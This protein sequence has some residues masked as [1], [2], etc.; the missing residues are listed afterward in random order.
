[1]SR[2]DLAHAWLITGPQYVGRRICALDM[3][4]AANCEEIRVADAVIPC[5]ECQQ[6]T[7]I[8]SAKH[9]DIRFSSLDTLPKRD[10]TA[11]RSAIPIEEIHEIRRLAFLQPLEGHRRVFIIGDADLLSRDAANALLKTLEE[12]PETVI[13]I[14][15]ALA[16]SLLP[17]TI[18][19]RCMKLELLPVSYQT[20]TNALV[21]D[22]GVSSEEAKDITYMAQGRIG[23]A[24]QGQSDSSLYEKAIQAAV[25]AHKMLTSDLEER[26]A[27][28]RNLSQNTRVSLTELLEELDWWL[29]WW[30]D[31]AYVKLDRSDVIINQR[32][33]TTLQN[34]AK[35]LNFAEISGALESIARAQKALRSNV[36]PALALEIMAFE[37]P[38][39]GLPNT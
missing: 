36:N 26:L 16:P 1:M 9:S 2:G 6:C 38:T 22:F 5:G 8:A 11:R 31:L 18:V 23:W 34:V 29:S 39:V 3:A 15:L 35:H 25:R 37:L 27:T 12:P 33:A 28:A 7:R 24:M 21:S 19:S 30:R 13:I 20:I 17:E 4:K 10:S 14:L 32:S